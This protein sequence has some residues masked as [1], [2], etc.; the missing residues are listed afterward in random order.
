[1]QKVIEHLS[2]EFSPSTTPATTT[3]TTT[4][5][6]PTTPAPTTAAPKICSTNNKGFYGD[7]NSHSK[8]SNCYCPPSTTKVV[9]DP[10][11]ENKRWKCN[12]N[13]VVTSSGNTVGVAGGSTGTNTKTCDLT[14]LDTNFTGLTTD[15]SNCNCPKNTS[16]ITTRVDSKTYKT[17]TVLSR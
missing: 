15:E 8:E 16:L 1:M 7:R 10:N 12:N 4:T 14:P 9:N 13:P 3:R 5:P 11:V 17:C 6:A 2:P